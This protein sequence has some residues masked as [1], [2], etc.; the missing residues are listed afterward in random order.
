MPPPLNESFHQSPA[1]NRSM[2]LPFNGSLHQSLAWEQDGRSRG[3]AVLEEMWIG[4]NTP[5]FPSGHPSLETAEWCHLSPSVTVCL[6]VCYCFT[7]LLGLV[8]NCC[9]ICIIGRRRERANVTN[10]L[11]A[12][13]SVSDI[14]M[15]AFCLPFTVTYTLMDHWVFGSVLCRLVPFIQCVSVTVSVLSLVLIALERH[16]LIINPSG[17]KPSIPQAY[18]AVIIIWMVAS[19]T[20]LPFMAF[21]LLTNEPYANLTQPQFKP[22]SHPKLQSHA[23]HQPPFQLQP[24]LYTQSSLYPQIQPLPSLQPQLQLFSHPDPSSF[25]QPPAPLW[26]SSHPQPPSD[27]TTSPSPPPRLFSFPQPSSHMEAC[28]EHWPSQQQKLAYTTWLLVFQYCGPLLL[29]LFCYIRVFVRL[30]HRQEMLD[31]ARTPENQRMTHSRR[32]NVMLVALVTA[33]ALCWLPLTMFNVVS[34]WY[35]EALPVCHH[36]LLFSLC[37][38]LA[39]SSTCINPIIYGFLNSNFRQEVREMLLHCRCQPLVDDYEH[40]PMSTVHTEV[41]RTSLQINCRNNSV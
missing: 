40:F 24:L 35:Q 10:I 18:V 20:S 7:M 19:F 8:G 6:V 23:K 12:N 21:H 11:I 28:L 30:R 36:D 37:H 27:P 5:S 9:L 38:L 31:Q 14:M 4:N 17:W 1:I 26:P 34:D 15:C 32:V 39:M 3:Q 2:S 13:L 16:Q 33:F 22:Q 29:V 41:S 25:P